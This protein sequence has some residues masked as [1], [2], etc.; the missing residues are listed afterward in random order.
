MKSK[1]TDR[2]KRQIINSLE[3]GESII[4]I[5]ICKA[6]KKIVMMQK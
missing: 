3:G 2:V 5:K 6:H 4:K 1:K